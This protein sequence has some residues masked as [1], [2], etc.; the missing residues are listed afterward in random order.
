MKALAGVL[1]LVLA[2]AGSGFSP[3]AAGEVLRPTV[4]APNPFAMTPPPGLQVARPSG[5]IPAR[6]PH[7]YPRLAPGVIYP[8]CAAGHWA[9]RWVPTLHTTYVWVPGYATADGTPVG[10][11]YLPRVVPGGYYQPVWV[12]G[13]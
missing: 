4:L 1:G 3:A 13:D 10:G 7:L 11:G 5:E 8:C 9:Y 6:P 12:S 2:I